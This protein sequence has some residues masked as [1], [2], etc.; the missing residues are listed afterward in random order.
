MAHK[1]NRRDFIVRFLGFEERVTEEELRLI[2]SELAVVIQTVLHS[3]FH[4]EE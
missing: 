3:N 4:K 2:E 1:S